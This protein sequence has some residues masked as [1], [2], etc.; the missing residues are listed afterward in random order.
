MERIMSQ[1][2]SNLENVNNLLFSNLCCPPLYRR[3]DCPSLNDNRDTVAHRSQDLF[4]G[5]TFCRV[6]RKPK[7]YHDMEKW[8]FY[9]ETFYV[10]AV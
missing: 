7:R 1:C 2:K 6:I 4:F 3:S 5:H 9:N 8:I 10:S